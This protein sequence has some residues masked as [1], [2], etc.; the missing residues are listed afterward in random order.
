MGGISFQLRT[1]LGLCRPHTPIPLANPQLM[2]ACRAPGTG[3]LDQLMRMCCGEDA[4]HPRSLALC[5]P[6]CLMRASHPCSQPRGLSP[7]TSLH[8]RR[9]HKA[10]L[11]L[12]W[13]VEH[14]AKLALECGERGLQGGHF[15]RHIAA[16]NEHIISVGRQRRTRMKG[17]CSLHGKQRQKPRWKEATTGS[18]SNR[19]AASAP[20]T[21]LKARVSRR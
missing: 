12:T 5:A 7:T 13:H 8:R 16:Y 11:P 6:A 18:E 1:K 10:A 4:T 2:V 20:S 21:Y 17:A 9:P 19:N 14:V 3:A 15:V